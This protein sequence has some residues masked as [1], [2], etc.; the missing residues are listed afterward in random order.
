M[1]MSSMFR[2]NDPY[3]NDPY[4]QNSNYNNSVVKDN[5][6]AKLYLF[7]PHRIDNAIIRPYVYN[8]SPGLN[9]AVYDLMNKRRHDFIS[10]AS[11]NIKSGFYLNE[12]RDG[13][14]ALMPSSNWYEYNTNFIGNNAW[15]F[16]LIINNAKNTTRRFNNV[17][18]NRLVYSGY[19]LE[20]PVSTIYGKTTINNN[21]LFF[22][23]HHTTLYVQNSMTPMGDSNVC[24]TY[25]DV[26]LLADGLTQGDANFDRKFILDPTK[27]LDS[28]SYTY[29]VDAGEFTHAE[30]IEVATMAERPHLENSY[31]N[32]SKQYMNHLMG[33]LF[34]V[35]T[36]DDHN[37]ILGGD[38]S[39]DSFGGIRNRFA[40]ENQLRNYLSGT[41][42]QVLAGLDLSRQYHTFSSIINAFPNIT[43][44]IEVIDIRTNESEYGLSEI[45]KAPNPVNI[46]SALIKSS[47]P[48][49]MANWGISDCSF[50]WASS[51]PSVLV[52]RLN[53]EPVIQVF[54]FRTIMPE[55]QEVSKQKFHAVLADIE[56]TVF[57]TI[58][59]TVGEFEVYINYTSGNKIVVQLQLRDLTDTINDAYV[60]GQ[61]NLGGL[62]SP[63]IGTENEYTIHRNKMS[64]MMDVAEAVT[65]YT[66]PVP[67]IQNFSIAA[68]PT[69]QQHPTVQV[70]RSPMT[71]GYLV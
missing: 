6:E 53:R 41:K 71:D 20:E 67:E 21:A 69:T 63:L 25:M 3:R 29:D 19:V 35:I 30:S 32:N 43:R 49:L 66:H 5:A 50:R 56:K 26:D 16:I 51:N 27:I 68:P 65:A 62:I 47:V 46:Y 40:R 22:I 33:G 55:S 37:N 28:S 60:V 36:E 54:E 70:P 4:G 11:G 17:N 48:P 58:Y 31:M 44:N 10:T 2:T 59:E 38:R 15:M 9:N 12:T 52:T 8:N 13:H 14:E 45:E 7:S 18:N 42:P 24:T 1:N 57:S 64:E 61:T 39:I 34:R 23:T